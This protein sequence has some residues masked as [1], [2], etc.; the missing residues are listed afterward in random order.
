MSTENLENYYSWDFSEDILPYRSTLYSL[1]PIGIGTPLVESLNSYLIRLAFVHKI[2]VSDFIHYYIAPLFFLR[3]LPKRLSKKDAVEQV[4][5]K[6]RRELYLLQRPDA[7]FWLDKTKHVSNL[8][9]VLEILTGREDIRYLTL[10]PWKTW[11]LSFNH[12]FNTEQ[13]W[14]VACYQN[15]CYS[16]APIYQPLL[17]ALETVSVCPYHQRYLQLRCLCC[18]LPQPFFK[19]QGSE[20]KCHCCGAWLGRFV[21]LPNYSQK[22]GLEFDSQLWIAQAVGQL[23]AATPSLDKIP[24]VQK[25]LTK[26]ANRKPTLKQFLRWCY[27]LRVSPVQGLSLFLH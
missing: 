26:K 13:P 10:L 23:L 24:L 20:G 19:L 6:L 7:R 11:P 3:E 25:I 8:V 15:W 1:Q 27:N 16:G 17:W 9:R 2:T 12:I 4:V 22:L 18:R 21:D 5:L 14:C